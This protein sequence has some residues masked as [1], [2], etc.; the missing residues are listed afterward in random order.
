MRTYT[1]KVMSDGG[2][3]SRYR[4]GNKVKNGSFFRQGVNLNL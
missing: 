3:N 1:M 2:D 4:A